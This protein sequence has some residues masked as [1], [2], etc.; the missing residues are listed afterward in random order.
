MRSAQARSSLDYDHHLRHLLPQ[1]S[2]SN[3]AV[4]TS[5]GWISSGQM[6]VSLCSVEAVEAVQV[7]LTLV[8]SFPLGC[9]FDDYL[10]AQTE[11]HVAVVVPSVVD[12]W[13]CAKKSSYCLHYLT[14]AS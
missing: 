6:S 5:D 2:S 13:S 3:Y 8:V 10:D 14:T 9:H 4:G 7:M 1:S 12:A 11:A